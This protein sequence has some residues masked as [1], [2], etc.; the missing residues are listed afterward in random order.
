MSDVSQPAKPP[1][2]RLSVQGEGCLPLPYCRRWSLLPVFLGIAM[3]RWNTKF[4]TLLKTK[5]NGDLTIAHQ[6]FARILENSGERIEAL[7]KSAEFRD[8]TLSCTIGRPCRICW[9]ASGRSS[10]WTFFISSPALARS[11]RHRRRT[12]DRRFPRIG[13]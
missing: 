7:G 6:Y 3:V 5:V 2:H 4:D 10:V 9:T 13:R 8:V 1:R 11:R 12:R